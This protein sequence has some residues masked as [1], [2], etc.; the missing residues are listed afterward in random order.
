[1]KRRAGAAEWTQLTRRNKVLAGLVVAAGSVAGAFYMRQQLQ[2]GPR[3]R[4][5]FY[6]AD[7][8]LLELGPEDAAAEELLKQG[9]E[10]L[11]RAHPEG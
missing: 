11:A 9:R 1:V 4:A 7:G 8:T 3:E 6:F 2:S 10:L 5:C